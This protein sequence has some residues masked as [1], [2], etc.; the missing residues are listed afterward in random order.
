LKRKLALNLT[1]PI[2]FLAFNVL[3]IDQSSSF[4]LSISNP[5][6]AYQL[7]HIDIYVLRLHEI[8]NRNRLDYPVH[9]D[10]SEIAA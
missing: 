4:S 2:L 6:T 7:C 9:T 5:F 10:V 1:V 8:G 3:Y